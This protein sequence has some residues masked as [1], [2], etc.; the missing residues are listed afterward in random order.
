[1]KLVIIFFSL[2]FPINSFANDKVVLECFSL[3]GD[4]DGS[5]ITGLKMMICFILTKIRR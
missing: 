5:N 2:L 4:Y 3:T 1:M